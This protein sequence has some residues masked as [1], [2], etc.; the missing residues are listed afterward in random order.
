MGTAARSH[1]P[2]ERP[3]VIIAMRELY[4]GILPA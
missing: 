2:P 3:A 4:D 1:G